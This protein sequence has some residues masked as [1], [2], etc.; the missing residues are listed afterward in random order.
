M[1]NCGC[2]DTCNCVLV[3]GPGISITGTGDNA[4]PFIVASGAG[5]VQV[6]DTPTV[7]LSTVGAGSA[8]DP[9]VISADVRLD[10]AEGNALTAGADGLRVDCDD[11]QACVPASYVLAQIAA[12]VQAGEGLAAAADSLSVQPSSDANNALSF[13]TD[14]GVF[15]PAGGVS[16]LVTGD[17]FTVDLNG[18]G[19]VGDPTTANVRVDPAVPNLLAFTSAGMRVAPAIAGGL[20]GAGT[21][22]VPFAVKVPAWDWSMPPEQVGQPIGIGAD[23][24]LYA[25]PVQSV[26]IDAFAGGALAYTA[27]AGTSAAGWSM[28]FTQQLA[29]QDPVRQMR[30]IYIIWVEV[31]LTLDPGAEV[32]VNANGASY[33]RFN[34][35]SS[36]AEIMYWKF[37]I[38]GQISIS[39][40]SSQTVTWTP[41]TNVT[42]G[43]AVVVQC[44]NFM[45]TMAVSL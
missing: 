25:P 33:Q 13:G 27:P 21:A 7:D 23:G 43:S 14:G 11:V 22:A 42:A 29:N 2:P 41:S 32:T 1:G 15:V 34:N 18:T 24:A 3:A 8:S 9:T 36:S 10:P 19:T 40:G 37:P 17:T 35:P 39:A 28:A 26:M 16:G 38:Y 4:D 6:A 12:A 31:R 45:R 44:Q 5:N 20:T 30:G